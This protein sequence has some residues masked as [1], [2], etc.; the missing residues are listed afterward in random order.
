MFI[1]DGML[2]GFRIMLIG[3]LLGKNGIF[4]IGKIFE[5]IFLFLWWLVIL[6][7]IDIFFF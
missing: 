5:I 3:V 2:S 1:C 6:L 4:L 7:L